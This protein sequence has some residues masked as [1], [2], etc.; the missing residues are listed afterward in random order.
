MKGFIIALLV[1]IL[2]VLLLTILWPAIIATVGAVLG[3]YS[4]NKLRESN[5]V[6]EKILYSILIAL[7]ALMIFSN[8][9]GAIAVIVV[10]AIVYFLFK[11]KK[12]KRYK[13]NDTFDYPYN[14]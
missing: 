2:A 7:G 13:E 3:F 8:L 1:I 9:K 5:S 10:A 4:Y 14:K 12:S 11:N 6:G